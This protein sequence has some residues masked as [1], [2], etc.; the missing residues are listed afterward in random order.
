MEGATAF[1]LVCNVLQLGVLSRDLIR[2]ARELRSSA[3]GTTSRNDSLSTAAESLRR[4]AQEIE[5]NEQDPVLQDLARKCQQATEEHI[6]LLGTLRLKRPNSIMDLGL[7][8][9]RAMY[10]RRD[11]EETQVRVDRL[12]AELTR[13]ITATYLPRIDNKID[14][15]MGQQTEGN[16]RAAQDMAIM[17][18]Q[19]A[20]V[21]SLADEGNGA[22]HSVNMAITELHQ[23]LQRSSD[24]QASLGCCHALYFPDIDARRSQVANAHHKT[25]EWILDGN[26][27]PP[28]ESKFQRWL[29]SDA[30]LENVFW[31][32]GKPGS[33]KSTL[34]KHLALHPQL[35]VHLQHW[36][37]GRNLLIVQY[38][39]WKSGSELQKSLEGLMRSLLYQILSQFPQLISMTFPRQDWIVAGP[40]F[41]FS[42]A[43]MIGALNRILSSGAQHDISF[44]FFID[45]LDEFD[46][47][48]EFSEYVSNEEELVQFLR[49]FYN[50]KHVKLCLASR[51]W[52]TFEREFGQD[53]ERCLYVHELTQDD[54]RT[55]IEDTFNNNSVFR[56]ISHGNSSYS[57]LIREMIDA[58][59]GVF[60]WV[61][62]VSQTLLNGIT[63]ADQISDLRRKLRGL[64]TQLTKLFEHILGD[65][66]PEYICRAARI[67]YTI[68]ATPGII[69]TPLIA[70]F[71][72]L[73]PC[74]HARILK[75][76]SFQSWESLES[77]QA[78]LF[79]RLDAYC[80]GL[81]QARPEQYRYDYYSYPHYSYD[82]YSCDHDQR[83][84]SH[85]TSDYGYLVPSDVIGNRLECFHHTLQEFLLEPRIQE[86]LIAK[87]NI[88]LDGIYLHVCR[89]Y[90]F[91]L[92]ALVKAARG[93]FSFPKEEGHAIDT[94][95]F[96][97]VTWRFIFGM[98]AVWGNIKTKS[99]VWQLWTEF[100]SFSHRNPIILNHEDSK[101]SSLFENART[102]RITVI[103][104]PI[105]M[106]MRPELLDMLLR[107]TPDR[108][109]SQNDELPPLFYVRGTF[110]STIAPTK[111]DTQRA[112]LLLQL[113]ADPNEERGDKR[114]GRT[115]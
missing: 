78:E 54:I 37:G 53:P 9:L 75:D 92:E 59:E 115:S 89:G 18:K 33:G 77:L 15:V 27:G 105:L 91:V 70:A 55:Y 46:N 109:Y 86:Y 41:N 99:L 61:R 74:E 96:V 28:V 60:L 114:H 108:L 94:K 83:P 44:I 84:L 107:T 62:I 38:Y 48:D 26:N 12:G 4:T 73:N 39:F 1:A 90:L 30:V 7:L 25:F 19:L 31:I 72:Y 56:Q 2:T 71:V 49:P 43:D 8:S 29:Q 47:R 79:T 111:H 17:K 10:K 21:K 65:I 81:L 40:S 42:K 98:L 93:L 20:R 52:P 106:G 66:E 112:K 101:L 63:N 88:E 82:Q 35:T 67:F 95:Q 68:S 103:G 50:C 100:E 3:T 80:K 22:V 51:R 102:S 45:G 14:V 87:A 13:H 36:S 85:Y 23:W 58:A 113:G 5:Q 6:A 69:F 104:F 16:K 32:S 76:E 110:H 34:M 11:L 64:P 24:V 97:D 57:Y